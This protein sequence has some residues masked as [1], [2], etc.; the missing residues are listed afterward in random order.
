MAFKNNNVD[1]EQAM[2]QMQGRNAHRKG[3][4]NVLKLPIRNPV[5]IIIYVI[6]PIHMVKHFLASG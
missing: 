2:R 4:Y 3:W 1:V 5:Y 6:I